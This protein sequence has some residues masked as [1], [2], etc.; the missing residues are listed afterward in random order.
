MFNILKFE[1]S[2]VM[3]PT[4]DGGVVD[5]KITKE[6]V[7]TAGSEDLESDNS[8]EFLIR[9]SGSLWTIFGCVSPQIYS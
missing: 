2:A 8:K 3:E 5:K 7:T 4:V 6:V 1:M 9:K